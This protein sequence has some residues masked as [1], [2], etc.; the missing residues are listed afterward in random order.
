MAQSR[1]PGLANGGIM[2]ARLN[3]PVYLQSANGANYKSAV[4]IQGPDNIN[5]QVWWQK[6]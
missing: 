3:Y 2:P 6:P 5:T 1:G 4:A